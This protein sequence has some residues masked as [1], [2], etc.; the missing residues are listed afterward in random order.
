MAAFLLLLS[1]GGPPDGSGAGTADVADRV[2][3]SSWLTRF[4]ASASTST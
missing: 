4:S 1:A 2:R 3:R